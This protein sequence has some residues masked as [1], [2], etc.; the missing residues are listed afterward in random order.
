VV[1]YCTLLLIANIP[2]ILEAGKG[3]F[4]ARANADE[5]TLCRVWKDFA[6]SSVFIYFVRI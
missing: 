3:S 4:I 2:A 1:K 6:Y 5:I